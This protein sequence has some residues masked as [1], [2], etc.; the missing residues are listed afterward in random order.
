MWYKAVIREI[1]YVIKN[2][3][4]SRKTEWLRIHVRE[5]AE[6][7][8]RCGLNKYQSRNVFYKY[9]HM[10]DEHTQ[11]SSITN[12]LYC[13]TD[14]RVHERNIQTRYNLSSIGL[15]EFWG[16]EW[17]H[18]KVIKT[19]KGILLIFKVYTFNDLHTYYSMQATLLLYTT[20]VVRKRHNCFA[21]GIKWY[22]VNVVCHFAV[23]TAWSV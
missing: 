12:V 2:R 21:E 10:Y 16:T 8:W 4:N 14:F 18:V 7:K 3:L 1:K 19:S 11:L 23:G 22:T 6:N 17:E 15:R 20:P 5:E 13:V 9:E